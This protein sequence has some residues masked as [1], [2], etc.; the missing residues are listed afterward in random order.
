[1]ARLL[2]GMNQ[3]TYQLQINRNGIVKSN[4]ISFCKKIRNTK[5]MDVEG[6]TDNFI[7]VI[8][9]LTPNPIIEKTFLL[10]HSYRKIQEGNSDLGMMTGE[11][12]MSSSP[13]FPDLKTGIAK[14]RKPC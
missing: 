13:P 3:S 5:L 14:K 1:M 6:E 7:K 11:S 9:G 4:G 12:H 8:C 2:L 10:F